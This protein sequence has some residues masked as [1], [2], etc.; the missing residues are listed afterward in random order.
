MP[1]YECQTCHK[2]YDDKEFEMNDNDYCS[3]DCLI[4]ARN[5][6]KEKE[7]PKTSRMPQ[8]MGWGSACF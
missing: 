2:A 7:P 5:A 8:S 4:V 1:K 6:I 3:H